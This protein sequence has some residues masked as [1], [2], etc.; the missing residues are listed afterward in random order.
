MRLS[1]PTH[2]PSLFVLDPPVLVSRCHC[3]FGL[4]PHLHLGELRRSEHLRPSSPENRGHALR[5]LRPFAPDWQLLRPLLTSR[6][7]EQASPFQAQGE[8]SPGKSALL[9]RTVAA[10]TSPGP[11]PRELRRFLSARPGRRRLGCGSCTSTR[12]LRSTLPPH[13]RSPSRS[14]ASLASLWPAWPGTCTPRSA[15]M[16]GAQEKNP[17]RGRGWK[18]LSAV[19]HQGSRSG[20]KSGGRQAARD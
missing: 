4:H 18:S 19:T 1:Y 17:G 6:S 11:W 3:L 7:A 2:R 20:R 9:H 5:F 14:C 13:A 16:L 12:G 10:F 15:P 8:I